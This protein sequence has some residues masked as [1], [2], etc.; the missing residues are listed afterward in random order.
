MDSSDTGVTTTAGPPTHAT[1]RYSAPEVFDHSPRSRLTDV[2][3]LG[4][5]LADIVSRLFGHKLDA[6]REFWDSNGSKTD[7][8]AEN[9]HAT[10]EWFE[11]LLQSR[12]KDPT[13]IL[14]WLVSFIKHI[15]LDRDRLQRPTVDQ[16]LSRLLSI[17]VEQAATGVN[18]WVGTCCASSQ[19]IYRVGAPPLFLD[20][21]DPAWYPIDILGLDR[22]SEA[23][24]FD[25]RFSVLASRTHLEVGID[26]G[27]IFGNQQDLSDFAWTLSELITD[28]DARYACLDK[29]VWSPRPLIAGT[30][31]SYAKCLYI[32][33]GGFAES[34]T[35]CARL[36]HPSHGLRMYTVR[37]I[38]ARFG[39]GSKETS[40]SREP[41][42]AMCFDPEEPRFEQVEQDQSQ[43]PV[44]IS[45]HGYLHDFTFQT[46]FISRTPEPTPYDLHV[47]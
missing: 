9:P 47:P 5:V 18:P 38:S 15:L 40:Y 44:C 20:T 31:M 14:M 32:Y 22:Q 23:I 16:V 46:P 45:S 29:P 33:P 6:I 28:S 2:W 35:I 4:C 12:P 8:Y 36:R 43:P 11:K 27:S 25:S 21:T 39:T 42:F 37:V 41:F 17:S 7:S 30:L 10:S 19:S 1:R 26:L 3:S 13:R 24:F 34:R